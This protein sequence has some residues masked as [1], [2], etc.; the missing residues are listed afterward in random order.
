MHPA[1]AGDLEKVDYSDFDPEKVWKKIF[2]RVE[3]D[4][5]SDDGNCSVWD[6]FYPGQAPEKCSKWEDFSEPCKAGGVCA[7]TVNISFANGS[8]I[9]WQITTGMHYG[10]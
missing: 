7:G 3:C 9:K 4:Y 5:C 1:D 2:K 8:A 6:N 10:T